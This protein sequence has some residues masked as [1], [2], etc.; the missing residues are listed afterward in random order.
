MTHIIKDHKR[1]RKGANQKKLLFAIQGKIN[2]FIIS[3]R[4]SATAWPPPE[5]KTRL[6][7]TRL[8]SVAIT[9]RSKSVRKATTGRAGKITR[10]IEINVFIFTQLCLLSTC[11]T[12]G[13]KREKW[14]EMEFEVPL[15][16]GILI[17]SAGVILL[18]SPFYA[19]FSF[20]FTFF[21]VSGLCFVFGAEMIALLLIFVY[22][23]SISILFLFTAMFIDLWASRFYSFGFYLSRNLAVA[24]LW[25]FSVWLI[26][27]F[28]ASSLPISLQSHDFDSSHF[29][30]VDF[31]SASSNMSHI[32]QIGLFLPSP[33]CFDDC[34]Y[35]NFPS[36][37]TPTSI[38]AI[39][40]V[41]P[42]ISIRLGCVVFST[43]YRFLIVLLLDWMPFWLLFVLCGLEFIVALIQAYVF[44]LIASSSIL[45]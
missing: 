22:L 44:T 25:C 27:I 43:S 14:N 26:P 45:K 12:Y 11:K 35:C 17:A 16:T 7:P 19:I 20:V 2:S 31:Y 18:R 32:N 34:C 10:R 6:G 3:L 36:W 4:A 39:L 15:G 13:F 33:S 8:W 37:R 23:G 9:W 21:F 40:G 30:W 5:I 29:Q 41:P 1:V 28:L 38:N 42:F 24:V